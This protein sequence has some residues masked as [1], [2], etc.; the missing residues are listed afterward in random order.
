M[1]CAPKNKNR[2]MTALGGG[3]ERTCDALAQ[4]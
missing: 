4:I 2:G 3:S 1:A